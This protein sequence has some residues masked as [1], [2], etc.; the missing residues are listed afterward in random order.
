MSVKD[1]GT[2]FGLFMSMDFKDGSHESVEYA[3]DG[4]GNMVKDLN[5]GVRLIEYNFL[6]L[7][8]RVTFRGLNNPV[9]EYVYSKGGKKLSVLHRS[10]SEKRT[11][12]DSNMNYENGSLKRILVDSALIG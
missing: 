5:K 11:D 10:S 1:K 8:S 3:Y 7:P 4:N 2:H 12:Y 9:N 6:N